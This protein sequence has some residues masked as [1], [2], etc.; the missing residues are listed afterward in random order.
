[1]IDK[2][3]QSLLQDDY[4]LLG[5][6]SDGLAQVHKDGKIGFINRQGVLVIPLVYDVCGAPNFSEGFVAVCKQGAWGY[7]DKKGTVVADFQ[8]T[9]AEPFLHGL[10]KIE[11][12]G[13]QGYLNSKGQVVWWVD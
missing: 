7:I 4:D 5:V 2:N 13:K 11:Q 9:K 1:M 3:G 10:A 8:Y 12:E 6:F